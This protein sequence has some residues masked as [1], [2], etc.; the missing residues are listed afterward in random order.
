MTARENV[1]VKAAR[2]LREG[3][4]TVTRVDGDLVEAECHG[5]GEVY[6]LGHHPRHRTGWWCSCPARGR[7]CHLAALQLV[8][9]VRRPA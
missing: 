2:Y 3:R 1:D 7:C 5:A 4:I 9:V 8:T 6:R